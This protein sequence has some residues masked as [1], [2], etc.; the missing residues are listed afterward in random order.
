MPEE[1]VVLRARLLRPEEVQRPTWAEVDLGAIAHN[2]QVVRET[3]APARVLAV[4]KADAYGHGA[5]PVAHALQ[6]AGVPWFGVA[7]AEEGFELRQAGVSADI[8]V[9]NGV[10]GR[11]HRDVLE[12]GLTPVVHHPAQLADFARAWPQRPFVYH[13]KVDTGMGRLGVLP[14]DL[15]AFLEAAD[16]IPQARLGGVLTHFAR[17]D[18][19][20]PAATLAQFERFRAALRTIR[21]AGHRPDVLHAANSAAAFRLP[22]S[23]LDLVRVGIAL[24]GY[25]PGHPAAARLQPALRWVTRIVAVRDLPAG[26]TIGYGGRF[27]TV[28][29]SRIATLPVGYADGLMRRHE[30]RGV[31]LVRGQRCPIVGAVSMDLTTVDVTDVP[32]ARPGDLVTLLGPPR[33]T[34]LDAEEVASALGTIPY[35]VLTS[36]G[37]RVPRAY[38]G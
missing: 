20:D 32:E 2:L 8:L 36:V 17:A 29:P 11:A 26:A 31:V 28:R 7:L 33:A 5:V 10:Y 1:T 22:A 21:A 24:Y 18:E 13:L 6:E 35:E 4:V 27:R 23:R 37:R 19:D 9:L 16:G 15:P 38:L 3:V 25:L 34:C 12:A 14:E 30:G